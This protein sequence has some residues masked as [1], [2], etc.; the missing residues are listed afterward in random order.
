MGCVIVLGKQDTTE[1]LSW[2]LLYASTF[3]IKDGDTKNIDDQLLHDAAQTIQLKV[4]EVQETYNAPV[5]WIVEYQPPMNP[6]NLLLIRNNCYIEGWL[7][8]CCMNCG[9]ILKKVYPSQVSSYFNFVHNNYSEKKRQGIALAKKYL[10]NNT[11]VL[12]DHESDSI[13]NAVF[14]LETNLN[15]KTKI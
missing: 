2:E 12:N 5:K 4:M 1:L 15:T 8:S 14:F 6:G 13:L 9:C 10:G 3:N 11:T 7:S